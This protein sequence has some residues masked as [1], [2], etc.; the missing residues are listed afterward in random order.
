MRNQG[1]KGEEGWAWRILDFGL[2]NA[3]VCITHDYAVFRTD[4]R[5][6]IIYAKKR[7]LSIW[8][9]QESR[10]HTGGGERQNKNGLISVTSPF[11]F[12]A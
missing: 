11:L 7:V 9:K 2:G 8:Q 6:D 10:C 1:G 3:R 12:V 4:L 5:V